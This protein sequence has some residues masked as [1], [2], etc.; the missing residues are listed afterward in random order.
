[1]DGEEHVEKQFKKHID[2][3]LIKSFQSFEGHIF[4]KLDGK[5][6]ERLDL[7]NKREK[8]LIDW[9]YT[10]KK[11]IDE[12][13]EEMEKH[14]QWIESIAIR[15]TVWL[16]VLLFFTGINSALATVF[17]LWYLGWL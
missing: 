7:L 6:G 12:H 10:L 16:L 14:Q 15:K 5:I 4:N 9:I 3:R 13:E 2:D 1:M 8:D 11:S 17:I